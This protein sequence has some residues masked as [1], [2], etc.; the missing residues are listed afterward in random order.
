MFSNFDIKRLAG[1]IIVSKWRRQQSL[2]STAE[3]FVFCDALTF[4]E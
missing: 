4:P 3:S 1:L 2:V